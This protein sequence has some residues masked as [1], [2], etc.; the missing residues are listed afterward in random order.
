MSSPNPDPHEGGDLSS[1][2]ATG[3][4][5]PNDAGKHDLLPSVPHPTEQA[6]N[7]AFH[8]N[9]LAS[10]DQQ[11]AVANTTDVSRTFQDDGATGE[12]VSG[13]G[14]QLPAGVERKR[15]G[16]EESGGPAA[17]GHSRDGKALGNRGERFDELASE[18][19]E[20]DAAPGEEELE[21]DEVRE[22]KGL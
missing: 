8:Q 11:G 14:D 5:I 4:T 18:G 7:P 19:P 6:E 3:T 17:K 9:L 12:V 1:M 13:T 22:G 2:A 15:L 16:A 20:A 21:Q 10:A